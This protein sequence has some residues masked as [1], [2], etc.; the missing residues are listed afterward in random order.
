M[1]QAE[2]M[3][4]L[5]GTVALEAAGLQALETAMGGPLGPRVL[6]AVDLLLG[7]QGRLILTGMGKSGHIARKIAATLASTGT[8]SHYVHPAEAS[9]GDLGMVTRQ[10][11]VMALSWSGEAPELAA[12]IAYTRRFAVPLI[13]LTAGEESALGSA[14]DICLTMPRMA[15]ACPH[16]LAPTTST[17]MTLALGDAIAMALLEA[18][19][20]SPQDFSEFHPGGKLGARL[21]RARDLMHGADELPLV[22]LDA[23]LAEAVVNMT[24]RRFGVTGITAADGTLAG[25][26]TDGDVRRA[27]Q[28][29]VAMD[30][31]V[32]SVMTATPRT[33]APETL[34]AELL[35]VM[36]EARITSLFVVGPDRVPVGILHLHDLLRAGVV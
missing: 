15:E 23:T 24:S 4:I 18:R 20:F 11:A 12:I 28:K 8:P 35:A 32:V 13:A 31:P 33:T 10:D 16:G 14:A 36:N 27:L 26:L 9:H 5:R 1:S 3:A 25:M 6:A 29:G 17:T 19:G 2:R 22:P 7:L 34:A 30:S 21:R